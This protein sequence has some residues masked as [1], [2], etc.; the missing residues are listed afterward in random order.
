ME[1]SAWAKIGSVY[2]VLSIWVEPSKTMLRIVGEEPSPALFEPEMFEVVSSAIPIAW[3]ITSPKAGCL[4]LG[5][6]AWSHPNFWEEFFDREPKAVEC[7]EE[8]RK[9]IIESDP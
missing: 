3:V 1:R 6:E 7:F 8:Y 4:S 2:H 5:P 9:L